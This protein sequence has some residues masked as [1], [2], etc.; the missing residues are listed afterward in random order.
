MWN[1]KIKI[2]SM[3]SIGIQ[4]VCVHQWAFLFG[5]KAVHWND[6]TY[7]TS[8]KKTYTSMTCTQS[9]LQYYK[10]PLQ[11]KSSTHQN[12]HV[13][14]DAST[15][16]TVLFLLSK[17]ATGLSGSTWTFLCARA[18]LQET[19]MAE[20]FMVFFSSHKKIAEWYHILD[21]CSIYIFYNSLFSVVC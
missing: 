3:T 8:G 4:W 18:T 19:I 16:T 7:I 1:Q 15:E 11:I 5:V 12:T 20:V 14:T 17:T 6:T 10:W 9:H 2:F 13:P 21:H